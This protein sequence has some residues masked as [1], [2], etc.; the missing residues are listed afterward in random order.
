MKIFV[1]CDAAT[2]GM[3]SVAVISFT[4]SI[5]CNRSQFLC[6]RLS[7]SRE[8]LSSGLFPVL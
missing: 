6:Y 7:G 2:F 4:D 3:G 8:D 5:F 1:K